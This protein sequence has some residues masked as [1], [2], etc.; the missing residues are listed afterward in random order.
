MTLNN[1][2]RLVAQAT[3][4]SSFLLSFSCQ[5]GQATAEKP[6]NCHEVAAG[7]KIDSTSTAADT[8]KPEDILSR[9]SIGQLKIGLPY[10]EVTSF[11]GNPIKKGER[12]FG[13]PD[14]RYYWQI[15][16]PDIDI[17]MASNDSLFTEPVI[18]YISIHDKCKL[19]TNWGMGI[20]SSFAEVKEAYAN[21]L[22]TEQSNDTILVAGSVYGGL[23]FN[24]SNGKANR[25][26]LGAVAE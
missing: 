22:D 2:K 21:D 9:E 25:I 6:E 16:Y 4:L 13:E 10:K 24:F 23:I 8:M 20:G 26:F 1:K 19:T 12:Y 3:I 18:A 15:N 7:V 11:L 5:N 14:G 17:T